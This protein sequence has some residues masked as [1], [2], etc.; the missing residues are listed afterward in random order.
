VLEK[1]TSNNNNYL[2]FLHRKIQF[3]QNT[4]PVRDK[5]G[6]DVMVLNHSVKEPYIP[7]KFNLEQNYPNPF[8]GK[9]K[10]KYYVPYKTKVVIMVF[11]SEGYILEKVIKKDHDAGVHEVEVCLNKLPA[12]V[13]FYQLIT[14]KFTETRCMELN[15]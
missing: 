12:G 15:K 4:K 10:I 2:N 11:N 1:Q 13:Y 9:A 8:N 5:E 14:D 6:F 3:T 7:L